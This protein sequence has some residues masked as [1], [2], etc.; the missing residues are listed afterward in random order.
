ME[1]VEKKCRLK[2]RMNINKRELVVAQEER[3]LD[4]GLASKICKYLSSAKYTS[5][6]LAKGL[7]I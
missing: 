1:L 4:S 5:K 6:H 7:G 2:T 3:V